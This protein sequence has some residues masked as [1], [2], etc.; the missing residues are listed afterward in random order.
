MG[1]KG[2]QK[3]AQGAAL[4]DNIAEPFEPIEGKVNTFLADKFIK[5]TSTTDAHNNITN[6][7]VGR[8]LAKTIVGG[9]TASIRSS[10]YKAR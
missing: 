10:S 6:Q 5:V 1:A 2:P 8:L 3:L 4:P 7:T 9:R